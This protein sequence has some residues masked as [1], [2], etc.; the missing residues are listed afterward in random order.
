MAQDIRELIKS[1][2]GEQEQLR[3]GHLSRFEQ[4]LEE[5]MPEEQKPSKPKGGIFLWMKIAAVL[6][7]AGGIVMMVYNN[8]FAKAEDAPIVQATPENT[9][10][11]EPEILL[12]AISPEFKKVED[13]Y[14]ASV[15]LE[16]AR[17]EITD[18]NKE[19]IDA[20]MK[21]LSD[22]DAEYKSLN[23]EITESGVSEEMVNA[24]IENLKL[25]VELMIKLK[26]KLKEMKNA[27][28][29]EAAIQTV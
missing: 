10:T 27:A 9:E 17:L 3:E 24:M 29:Q 1:E 11:V 22:L 8:A 28:Q 16:I 20:F 21:Q 5:R 19:L 6:I 4:L 7:I 12:S 2:S 23:R 13:Y 26:A 15:N 18:D 14:L 25:R